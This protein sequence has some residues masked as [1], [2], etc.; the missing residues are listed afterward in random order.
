MGLRESEKPGVTGTR[1][2]H[3]YELDDGTLP[4]IPC[5][6]HIQNQCRYIGVRVIIRV[7]GSYRVT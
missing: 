1:V 3:F 5:A 2:R 6:G 7:R 4:S